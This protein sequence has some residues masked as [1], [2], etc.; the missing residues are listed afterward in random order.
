VVSKRLLTTSIFFPL[1]WNDDKGKVEKSAK[2]LFNRKENRLRIIES[3][4]EL[5]NDDDRFLM[6]IT[7]KRGNEEENLLTHQECHQMSKIFYS[8]CK[9]LYLF[10]GQH[11]ADRLRR[12]RS[13]SIVVN[14]FPI[15]SSLTMSRRT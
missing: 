4:D 1:I 10:R 12:C 13:R 14:N 11:F 15:R 3:S 2:N 8:S 5:F 6:T 7:E 9:Y